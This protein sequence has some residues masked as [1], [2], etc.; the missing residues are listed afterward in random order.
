MPVV[1]DLVDV[2]LRRLL[3]L[4]LVLEH[5]NHLQRA[6]PGSMLRL[7]TRLLEIENVVDQLDLQ[8]VDID[9]L[10]QLLLALLNDITR[11][12]P[13]LNNLG[14]LL[15]YLVPSD[16]PL[17]YREPLSHRSHLQCTIEQPLADQKQ[18]DIKRLEDAAENVHQH[19]AKM[20][21]VLLLLVEV[22][23]L[24]QLSGD[25]EQLKVS[26]Q[27]MTLKILSKNLLQVQKKPFV[28][29]NQIK[30]DEDLLQS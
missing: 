24:R 16:L 11:P 14:I 20:T 21:D 25:L 10:R 12:G 13:T 29:K 23:Q 5:L 4:L 3:R 19:L 30:R 6:P 8:K 22:L 1:E 9:V 18:G 27:D 7:V 2:L 15:N 26:L 28:I 17:N